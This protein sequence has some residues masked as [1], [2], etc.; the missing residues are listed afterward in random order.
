MRGEHGA[1]LVMAHNGIGSSPHARGARDTRDRGIQPDGIIPACAGS[2]ATRR[3][4]SRCR[5]DHPR[6][7]GEHRSRVEASAAPW[8]SSPHARGAPDI[9]LG[10]GND[11]GIIPACAGSTTERW[12]FSLGRW[13]HPR[14]RGEHS[15][16]SASLPKTSPLLVHFLRP[17]SAAGPM[18]NHPRGRNFCALRCFDA[19]LHPE[20]SAPI[21]V[22]SSVPAGRL[23]SFNP[24]QSTGTQSGWNT[25]N[26]RCCSL[27]EL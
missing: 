26:S 19:L 27:R 24:S 4:R 15:N 17:A 20:G 10:R 12:Q 1:P 13:D 21:S 16:L 14:M 2:T 11:K 18:Q 3:R 9:N 6:M 25:S 8:G 22:A 5:G 23:T 7:R